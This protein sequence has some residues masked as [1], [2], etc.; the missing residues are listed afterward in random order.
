MLISYYLH[1]T[2]GVKNTIDEFIELM[3]S[4]QEHINLLAFHHTQRRI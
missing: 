4:Q 1:N 2:L 3:I